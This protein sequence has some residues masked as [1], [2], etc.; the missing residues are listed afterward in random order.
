MRKRCGAEVVA[1][2]D[3]LRLRLEKVSDEQLRE[4]LDEYKENI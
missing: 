1:E 4:L 3:E 2:L